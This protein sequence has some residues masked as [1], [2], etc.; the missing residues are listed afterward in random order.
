LIRSRRHRAGVHDHHI[1]GLRR[2]RFGSRGAQLLL[3]AERV[4]LIDAAPEGNDRIFHRQTSA[5]KLQTSDFE[6]RTFL[7]ISRRYCIPSKVIWSTPAYARAIASA[8]VV[9]RP[10][11]VSTRPPAVTR[12]SPWRLVPA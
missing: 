1:C 2:D 7:P 8:R 9:P 3:E 10:T 12:R 11:T 4:G 6:L 5:L